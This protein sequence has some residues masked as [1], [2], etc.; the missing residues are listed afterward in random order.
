[1]VV[2][3][4]LD[5]NLSSSQHRSTCPSRLKDKTLLPFPSNLAWRREAARRRGGCCYTR[6][7][8]GRTGSSSTSGGP[9]IWS[10][11]SDRNTKGNTAE[12]LR[13]ASL[14]WISVMMARL[15]SSEKSAAGRRK[16]PIVRP[17]C[18]EL[19]GADPDP[20]LDS[21]RQDSESRG[22]LLVVPGPMERRPLE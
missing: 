17:W 18:R 13:G 4:R 12:G 9:T 20:D 16:G 2:T 22:G 1:M 21:G 7:A 6:M 10:E 14:S 5:V 8:P 3:E 11:E 19:A 15:L